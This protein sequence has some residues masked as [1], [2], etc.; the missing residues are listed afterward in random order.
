MLKSKPVNHGITFQSDVLKKLRAKSKALNVSV[1]WCVNEACRS[2]LFGDRVLVTGQTNPKMNG[3]FQ[4]T[5]V[6]KQ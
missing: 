6:T 5:K 3:L 4:L 2:W 1:N